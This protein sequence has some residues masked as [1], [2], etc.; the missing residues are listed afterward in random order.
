MKRGSLRVLLV[1]GAGAESSLEALLAGHAELSIDRVEAAGAQAAGYD[2]AVVDL[3]LDPLGSSLR[4]LCLAAPSLPIVAI[5]DHDDEVPEAIMSG[6]KDVI[7]RREIEAR[8]LVKALR[9]AVLRRGA[10]EALQESEQRYALAVQGANDGLWDWHLEADRIHY[11][12]RW[13]QMLGFP[14]GELDATSEAWF[15]RIHEDDLEEVKRSLAAHVEGRRRTFHAEYRM[16][17]KD[18]SLRWMLARGLAIRDESGRAFRI[19]G[20]QTDIS[21]RKEAELALQHQAWH[22]AVTGLPNRALLL[23]RLGRALLRQR[24]HRMPFAV[25]AMGLDNYASI[26][27]SY[28]HEICEAWTRAVAEELETL[29]GA[30]DTLARTG[31]D[32]F[33]LLVDNPP[34][35][36]AVIRIC[37][38][39]QERMRRPM[40]VGGEELF[41]TASIGVVPSD[42]HHAD[43]EDYLRDASVAMNRAKSLGG[44]QHRVFDTPMHRHVVERLQLEKELRKAIDQKQFELRYQPIVSLRTGQVAGF[45]ALLRWLHPRR[46]LLAPAAFIDTAEAA[47]L[48]PAIFDVIFPTILDELRRWQRV[49]RRS[50]L[51][52]NVNLSRSQFLDPKLIERV[53][54]MLGDRPGD[55]LPPG[56]LGFELTESMMVDDASVLA[57]LRA[58]KDRGIRLLLDDFGTGYSS[59][60]NLLSFPIDAIKIDRTFLRDLGSVEDSTEIIRAMV[61]LAHGMGMEVTVEGIET[62]DQLRFV[63][64]LGCA[65]GQG[66]HFAVPLDPDSASETI[67]TGYRVTAPPPSSGVNR[68][69]E[70]DRGRVF[71][72]DH[73]RARRSRLRL[74]LEGEGFSVTTAASA[75]ECLE[76]AA[77]DPPDVILMD[78]AL[79]GMDGIEASRRLKQSP[80]S[81]TIPILLSSSGEPHERLIVEA[82]HAG[83]N[84]F[85]SKGTPLPILCARLD[86]Q[87]AIGRTQRRL[88][89]IAM[90]D[91]LTGVFTRRFM[92][93]ALRRVLKAS[94]RRPPSGMAVLVID[95]DRL[96]QLNAT[97]GVIEGDRMLRHL[98]RTVDKL[99][100]ETDLVAR[101][102]GEEFVVVL[103]D[104]DL[105]GAR[106]AAEKIRATVEQRCDTTVS[107]GGAFMA[108]ASVEVL[109][110]VEEIDS[111]IGEMLRRAEEAMQRAKRDGR[112]RVHFDATLADTATA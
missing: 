6:A 60:S 12:D 75:H 28:G 38:A 1:Q 109:R 90:V 2:V 100:R 16:R 17:H 58:L 30:T 59:L 70:D 74:S 7:L 83:G 21:K 107:I 81:A 101:F 47:G 43:A 34:D 87:V 76:S 29:R 64:N 23:D 26:M 108:Q 45:E 51:F 50:A 57:T 73:D 66:Y 3:A 52:V 102:G 97:H 14:P 49:H 11:S 54:A 67:A 13:M 93:Q 91:E 89:Q 40:I 63:T 53:D 94:T 56:S 80:Q 24:Q 86:S 79:P 62:D 27:D 84:D 106:I 104:T 111:L 78:I 39:I 8:A 46:G 37:D 85:V 35:L 99:T 72:V 10:V 48:L 61:S 19:A 88:S 42:E 77:T 110:D 55:R 15:G 103:E 9:I 96:K 44:G 20:S 98:A 41:T 65:F 4:S 112:N 22:D 68:R 25:I 32:Q 92:L 33:L 105:E 71:L 95:P 36:A 5:V 69:V 18:G 31:R 82:L